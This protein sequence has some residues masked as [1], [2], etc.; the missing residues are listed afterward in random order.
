M[1]I[2]EGTRHL[3]YAAWGSIGAPEGFVAPVR[4]GRGTVPAVLSL[5]HAAP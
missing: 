1:V 2:V 3:F 4:D 5:L